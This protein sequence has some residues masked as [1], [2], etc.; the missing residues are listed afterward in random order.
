MSD[1]TDNIL[2]LG[3]STV[4]RRE[5][6]K[7]NIERMDR[8]YIVSD[9]TGELYETEKNSLEQNGYTVLRLNLE[10]DK[11]ESAGYNPLKYS[12]SGNFIA[13]TIYDGMSCPIKAADP[14][15]NNYIACLSALISYTAQYQKENL[16]DVYDLLTK[17]CTDTASALKKLD[18]I[19]SGVEESFCQSA[20]KTFKLCS[21]KDQQRVIAEL[22]VDLDCFSVDPYKTI[23]QTDNLNLD[24]IGQRKTAI[25]VSDLGN[26]PACILA[27][28]FWNQA[29][30]SIY[31]ALDK[32]HDRKNHQSYHFPVPVQVILDD[33]SL[34][35]LWDPVC[36]RMWPNIGTNHSVSEYQLG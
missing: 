1:L 16:P 8:S 12:G 5:F 9:P 13:E 18:G 28:I 36:K 30:D 24:E 33:C 21:E 23:L 6:I 29:V 22:R 19:F 27:K 11:G 2:L 15:H 35:Y 3:K 4:K 20:Y 26:G 25:F 34:K 32:F 7:R 10:A 14:F 17:D 31:I